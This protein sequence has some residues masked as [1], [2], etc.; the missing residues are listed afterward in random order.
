MDMSVSSPVK[1]TI[2][3][4]IALCATVAVHGFDAGRGQA[5]LVQENLLWARQVASQAGG[6]AFVAKEHGERDPLGW[7]VA[8]LGQGEE[9]R[10]MR[11]SSF[12]AEAGSAAEQYRLDVANGLFDYSKIL[13][14]EDGSGV[15][16]KISVGYR[17]FLGSKS[18]LAN[19]ALSLGCFVALFW[20]VFSIFAASSRSGERRRQSQAPVAIAV[21]PR[22]VRLVAWL[23]EAKTLFVDLGTSVRET[24]RFAK[25]LFESLHHVRQSL[26][27]VQGYA[28]SQTRE[29][30]QSRMILM[31]I[32]QSVGRARAAAVSTMLEAARFG[33]QGDAL[34][35]S[36]EQMHEI[37]Q[38]IRNENLAVAAALARIEATIRPLLHCTA[39]AQ[40]A[41]TSIADAE[42]G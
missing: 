20:L 42:K 30:N 8:H 22:P 28:D 17:G 12:Q 34:R 19:D 11:I 6:M 14:P 13:M 9:P 5:G 39:Q 21:P 37:A 26:A 41:Y 33:S 1:I 15:R 18:R 31:R 3:A 40:Q 24:Y 7:S 25:T 38:E 32:E 29:L 27:E 2:S 35:H 4:V 16:I 10:I 23:T 36:A